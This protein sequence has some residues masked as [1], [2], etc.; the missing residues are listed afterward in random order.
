VNRE[1]AKELLPIITAFANGEDI[2]FHDGDG[3]A[4][5]D[6]VI[7]AEC[8]DDDGLKYRIKPKLPLEVYLRISRKTGKVVGW[9][10]KHETMHQNPKIMHTL[11]RE[12][13][14]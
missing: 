5:A 4:D 8:L 10:H 14:E 1:R 11:F 3:W 9:N 13:L 2:Q 7:E 6:S 12:V